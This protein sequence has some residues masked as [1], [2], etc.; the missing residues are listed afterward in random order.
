VAAGDGVEVVKGSR[1]RL[2]EN[3]LADPT[4]ILK[5]IGVLATSRSQRRIKD[6]EDIY[7]KTWPP[8]MTPDIPGILRDMET[9][10]RIKPSRLV[11]G[12]ALKDTGRLW[13]SISWQ[14]ISRDTVEIG[15]NIPY[16]SLHQFGIPHAVPVSSA[17]KMNLSAWLSTTVGLPFRPM[18]EWLL[19]VDEFEITPIQREFIGLSDQDVADIQ[20]MIL[21]SL[22]GRRA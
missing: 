21:D 12:D 17:A 13:Q 1:I 6:Q 8:R 20:A 16:A 19:F 9:G 14:V 3:R 4:V 10:S 15:T 2:I 22:L 11:S 18:F 7:G 5:R